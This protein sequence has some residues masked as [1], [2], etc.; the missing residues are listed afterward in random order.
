MSND[1]DP[2]RISET[3]E[4]SAKGCGWGCGIF[5]A[6]CVLIVVGISVCD[7]DSDPE[8]DAKVHCE[9]AIEQRLTSAYKWTSYWNRFP[10]SSTTIQGNT[11]V[12]GDKLMVQN[13][14]G[15]ERRWNYACV[16]NPETEQI[17]VETLGPVGF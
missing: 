4:E 7:L 17:R 5:I 3:E 2:D 10:N 13:A 9:I 12:W 16:W 14:F 15:A 6:L 11:R 1:K 8:L